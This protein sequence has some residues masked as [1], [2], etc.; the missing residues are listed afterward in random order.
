MLPYKQSK[1]RMSFTLAS[2]Y[3]TTHIKKG[4]LGTAWRA[5]SR[6]KHIADIIYKW[7]GARKE[8]EI[9]FLDVGCRDGAFTK[10]LNLSCRQTGI[11]IDSNALLEYKLR[12]H[13]AKVAIVDCNE[14]LPFADNSFDIILAGEIIEHLVNPDL[15]LSEIYRIL[16]KDGIFVG[17]TP[18]AFRWDKRLRLLFGA[19][20]KIFSDST[21]LQYFSYNSLI[22][23]LTT[24]FGF[25][26]TV[27]YPVRP[28]TRLFNKI[29]SSGFIWQA[30]K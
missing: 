1:N 19:D 7:K 3:K 11:D 25:C 15:F 23:H 16:K 5:E 10:E 12:F 8:E 18:N 21:H 27:C 30:Q 22:R 9:D 20:P 13:K 28:L 17:S 14:N 26:K 2:L 4:F 29:L 24:N 6:R